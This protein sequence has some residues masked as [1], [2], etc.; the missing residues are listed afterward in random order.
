MRCKL[1]F[2]V[3]YIVIDFSLPLFYRLYA[4]GRKSEE[5]GGGGCY[6]ESH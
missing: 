3:N 4:S 5:T 2:L 6:T 1:L